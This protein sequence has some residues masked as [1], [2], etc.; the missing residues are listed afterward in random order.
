MTIDDFIEYEFKL[1][2]ERYDEWLNGGQVDNNLRT[3]IQES[4][5]ILKQSF[6]L[7]YNK[8]PS[9]DIVEWIGFMSEISSKYK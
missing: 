1:Y 5:R 3:L 6:R 4:E 9:K 2:S 7:K 8:D